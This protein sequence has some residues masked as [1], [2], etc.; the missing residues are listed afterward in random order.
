MH[1]FSALNLASQDMVRTESTQLNSWTMMITLS[2]GAIGLGNGLYRGDGNVPI[3]GWSEVSCDG[4]EESLKNCRFL[5]VSDDRCE[6]SSAV[7]QGGA[8]ARTKG[9]YFE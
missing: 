6:T 7:C 2:A 4:S 3:A 8:T 1:L 9:S 5:R